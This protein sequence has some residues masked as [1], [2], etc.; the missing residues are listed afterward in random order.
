MKAE[1]I[2]IAMLFSTLSLAVAAKV[3]QTRIN[4]RQPSPTYE[5]QRVEKH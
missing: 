3:A 1:R 5:S 4:W 2:V